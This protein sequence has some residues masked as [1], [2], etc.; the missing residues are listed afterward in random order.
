[1]NVFIRDL[2]LYLVLVKY[3][4]RIIQRLQ[5]PV[6][7]DVLLLGA[8]SA[9]LPATTIRRR[10]IATLLQLAHRNLLLQD[11]VDLLLALVYQLGVRVLLFQFFYFLKFLLQL[12]LQIVNVLA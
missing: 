6:I 8:S 7:L 9:N 4:L 5:L 1:M 11:L 2:L 10:L 3:Q 12:L